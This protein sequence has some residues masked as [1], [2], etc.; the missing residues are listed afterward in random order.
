MHPRFHN[1]AI[2]PE[3]VQ[4]ENKTNRRPR[5]NPRRAIR[6]VQKLLRELKRKRWQI[7][8]VL[9]RLDRRESFLQ[10]AQASA[11]R[12]QR[13]N[14]RVH[15]GRLQILLFVGQSASKKQAQVLRAV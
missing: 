1:G 8:P 4:L 10:S 15:V 6:P 3:N 9:V 5:Y 12:I 14:E 2:Q 11:R 13:G 7:R